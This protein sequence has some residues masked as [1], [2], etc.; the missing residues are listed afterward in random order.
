V[1]A[2]RAVLPTQPRNEIHM[3]TRTRSIHTRDKSLPH[4]ATRLLATSGLLLGLVLAGCGGSGGSTAPAAKAPVSSSAPAPIAPASPSQSTAHP[5]TAAPPAASAAHAG[6]GV[7]QASPETGNEGAAAGAAQP[8]SGS[9]P[10]GNG[11]DGDGDN[12]GGPSDGDGNV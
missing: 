6:S 2:A 12:N 1:R 10:Q 11:G 8:Q 5:T 4:R 3:N 7:Q 9:I